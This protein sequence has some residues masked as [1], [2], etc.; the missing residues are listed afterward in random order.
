MKYAFWD[1]DLLGLASYK[2]HTYMYFTTLMLLV[3]RE[4]VVLRKS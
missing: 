3:R 4:S 1:T 2:T